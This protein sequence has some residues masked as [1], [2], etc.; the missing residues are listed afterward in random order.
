MKALVAIIGAAIAMGLSVA[1]A[2]SSRR[3]SRR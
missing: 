3:N 1:H 2:H